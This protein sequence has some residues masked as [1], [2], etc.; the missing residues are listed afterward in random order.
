[1]QKIVSTSRAF[2]RGAMILGIATVIS[3][4][5]GSIYTILL[6]N[7]I[8]DRGMGLYQMAY[9]VYS[10][11]LIV[12]TAGF[13]IAVSKFVSEYSALGDYQS[14]RRIYHVS[15][16]LL[17]VLGL[18]AAVVLYTQAPFF[19]TLS[20][21]SE[22]VYAIR[23]IAPALFIVP[24]MSTMRGYFQGWQLMNPTA[25]SQIM[26]QLIRVATILLGAMIVLKLGF[27]DTGAAA[28]AAF[29]AVTGGI[30]GILVMVYYMVAFKNKRRELAQRHAV[31]ER[32]V[33]KPLSI[34]A[35]MGKML[36]YALPVSLG[37]LIIPVISNVDAWTVTNILKSHGMAQ[38]TATRE[39]GL[40]AGRS[41]KLLMLP[42]ALASSLGA[43]LMPSV[44]A[45]FALRNH[46]DLH[47]R[48]KTGLHMAL[49]FALPASVGLLV[50]AKPID[51]ALFKDAAGYHSIQIMGFA[52]L[53]SVLQITLSASLQGIGAVWVPLWGL[54]AGTAA[55][56]ALNFML[57]PFFG[58]DGAAISTLLSY[59]LATVLNFFSLRAKIGIAFHFR[60]DIL[61][62]FVATFIMGAFI[63]A[64]Y[65]QWS[66]LAIP[67]PPRI[68][69]FAVT[70][71]DV[72][73]G[74]VLYAFLMVLIGLVN[75]KDIASLPRI[76]HPLV[77]VFRRFGLFAR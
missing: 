30:A 25:V 46:L 43:A 58:I 42:A 40:L 11:L 73:M 38:A 71:L 24:A 72:C 19:S 8:G 12:S 31:T 70:V 52:V 44:S 45:A 74:I 37:A 6:Q 65:A 66:R 64:L 27:G 9:P 63:F 34:R 20:G 5:M 15:L 60:D 57:I 10:T 3:K 22:A 13:P 50:L 48:I 59:A 51:I 4:M 26:E 75:E 35:I 16:V 49:W 56:I 62:P 53:F 21:D 76:G 29:G 55:K 69:A 54:F 36:Y 23:A 14:A 18:V 47:A 7:M 33:A 28:A 32:L 1:M 2:V 41:F 17:S 68:D 61:K 67:I 39:F 77:V